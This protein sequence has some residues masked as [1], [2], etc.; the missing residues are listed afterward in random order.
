M[1]TF[2]S[3]MAPNIPT[4]NE[5]VPTNAQRMEPEAASAAGAI[6]EIANSA[7]ALTKNM[8]SAMAS[9]E[10]GAQKT[11][12]SSPHND[13]DQSNIRAPT[14]QGMKRTQRRRDGAEHPFDRPALDTK[15]IHVTDVGSATAATDM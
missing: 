9:T 15:R 7:D 11:E 10:S 8:G 14:L 4:S 2:K 5:I 1:A 3:E 6:P 13:D 12:I